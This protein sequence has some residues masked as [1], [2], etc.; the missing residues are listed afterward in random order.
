MK[1]KT[2]EDVNSVLARPS[3][4]S[5]LATN[6]EILSSKIFLENTIDNSI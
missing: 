3:L 4:F 6:E 2:L 1:T 5:M